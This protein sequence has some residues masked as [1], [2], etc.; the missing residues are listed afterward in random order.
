MKILLSILLMSFCITATLAQN[1]YTLK[2]KD[3]KGQPMKNVVVTAEN[4]AENV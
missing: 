2:I 3:T 1:G 4:K